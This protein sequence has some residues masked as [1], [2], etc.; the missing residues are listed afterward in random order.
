MVAD[1]EVLEEMDAS[2]LHARRLNAKEMLT[3]QTSG[4]F[5]FLVADGTIQIFGRGQ[6]LRTS[7]LTRDRPERGEEQE[8]LQGKSDELHSPTQ[9]QHDSTRDVEEAKS[10]F[11]TITGEFIY[12]HHVEPRVKLYMLKEETFP[13]PMKYIDVTRTTKTSMDV[14]LEKHLEDYWNVDGEKELSDAWIDFTRFILLNERPPDGYTWSGVRLTRKQISFRPDDVW[15]D[16]WKHMC[17]ASKKKAKIWAIEKPKLDNARELRG[18]FFIQPNDEEF[19]LTVKAA[20]RKLKVPMPAAILQQ[21]WETQ[22]KICL[23]C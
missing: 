12:R 16:M 4:N 23:C 7:T 3:P 9:L 17:A 1:I 21:Y 22:D 8:I 10:D 2:E 19:K 20:R 6:R 14:L 13:I 15:P 5:I 11:W 18:I